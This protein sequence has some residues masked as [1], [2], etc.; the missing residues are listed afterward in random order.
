MLTLAQCRITDPRLA[1][2]SDEE[3]LKI[4]DEVY[5]FAQVAVCDFIQKQTGSM[6]SPVV[7]YP[8]IN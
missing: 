4:R 5:K 6:V 3:L 1:L 2:I 7:I 8:N